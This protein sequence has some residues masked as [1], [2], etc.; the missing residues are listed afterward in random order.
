MYTK[1]CRNGYYE[2][3]GMGKFSY[4]CIAWLV[5]HELVCLS[6]L[7]CIIFWLKFFSIKEVISIKLIWL[8][9]VLP[10]I[11]L[12]VVWVLSH[13]TYS[14]LEMSYRYAK[15]LKEIQNEWNEKKS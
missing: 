9:R 4:N 13:S 12:A 8:A 5:N 10:V 15:E 1:V 6:V 2:D 11:L 3:V 14:Y 7:T